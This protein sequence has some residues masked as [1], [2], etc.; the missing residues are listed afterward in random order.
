[1]KKFTAILLS[2]LM[3]SLSTVRIAARGA[4]YIRIQYP[5]SAFTKDAI[6]DASEVMCFEGLSEDDCRAKATNPFKFKAVAVY[7]IAVK[8]GKGCDQKLLKAL[9]S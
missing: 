3:L 5:I 9:N 8:H 7:Y 6:D 1:M 2:L 4:C